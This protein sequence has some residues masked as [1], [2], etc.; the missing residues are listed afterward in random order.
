MIALKPDLKTSVIP[1]DFVLNIRNLVREYYR[2][3][4]QKSAY[5]NKLT[6]VLKVSFPE[7]I[8]VFSKITVNTSL[9]LL[10]KYP[11]PDAFLSAR[12]SS[13]INL[14]RKTSHFGESYAEKQYNKLLT[15]ANSAKILGHSLPSDSELIKLYLS[16]IK[17]YE[18]SSISILQSIQ[19]AVNNQSDDC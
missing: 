3:K 15:A 9:A 13:I 19:T 16:L 5:V 1:S 8:G 17:T 11:S 4:D 12:K 7:Y 14:I 2:L 18:N 10:D 6:A